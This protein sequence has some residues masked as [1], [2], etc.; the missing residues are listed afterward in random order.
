MSTADE[1]SGANGNL[2]VLPLAART[3]TVAGEVL[4]DRDG[5]GTHL[6]AHLHFGRRELQHQSNAG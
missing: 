6:L 5:L 2:N 3:R 4:T 1:V